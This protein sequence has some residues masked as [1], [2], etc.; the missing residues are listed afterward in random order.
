LPTVVHP[1]EILD[2]ALIFALAALTFH[3]QNNPVIEEL[4]RRHGHDLW[5]A[6]V[7]LTLAPV[8]FAEKERNALLAARLSKDGRGDYN[9]D[10]RRRG[11]HRSHADSRSL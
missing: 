4:Y 3:A 11:R 6:G 9:E 2:G 1:N 10:R 5:F 8:T 7:V